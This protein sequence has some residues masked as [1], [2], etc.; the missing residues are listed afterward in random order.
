MLDKRTL[1]R[2]NARPRGRGRAVYMVPGTLA[3]AAA[4][5][6]LLSYVVGAVVLLAGAGGVFLLHRRDVEVRTTELTY[7]PGRSRGRVGLHSRGLPS[8]RERQ[9][10]VARR[11]RCAGTGGIILLR[12][13]TLVRSRYAAPPGR[14]WPPGD[15]RDLDERALNE[16][17]NDLNSASAPC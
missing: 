1:N 10:V 6:L 11:G 8:P 12:R 3:F 5:A 9:E 7:D 16:I 15:A 17:Q 14:G 13:G 2:I 4:A